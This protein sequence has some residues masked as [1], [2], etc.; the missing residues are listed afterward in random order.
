[1]VSRSLTPTSTEQILVSFVTMSTDRN[2]TGVEPSEDPSF[3]MV[4]G[5]CAFCPSSV[6]GVVVADFSTVGVVSWSWPPLKVMGSLPCDLELVC[7]VRSP[8]LTICGPAYE[9]SL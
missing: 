5:R 4:S 6:L 3:N 1:M 7:I 9:P 8:D 2:S